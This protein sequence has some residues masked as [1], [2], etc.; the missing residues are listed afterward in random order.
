MRYT[1]VKREDSEKGVFFHS[2]PRVLPICS[3]LVYVNTNLQLP[4][5][6][7]NSIHICASPAPDF[8]DLKLKRGDCLHSTFPWYHIAFTGCTLPHHRGVSYFIWPIK[9]LLYVLVIFPCLI[10]CTIQALNKHLTLAH[11]LT[12]FC[13]TCSSFSSSLLPGVLILFSIFQL[14]I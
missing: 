7:R 11:Q 3:E 8:Y 12:I 5:F 10:P 2:S 14:F 9:D 6:F 1:R 4:L 13:T